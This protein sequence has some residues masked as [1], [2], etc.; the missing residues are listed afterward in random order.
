M[1]KPKQ[2][3]SL[4]H[5]GDLFEA[6]DRK[7]IELSHR[8][9]S[10]DLPLLLLLCS[11]NSWFVLIVS[12]ASDIPTILDLATGDGIL[13]SNNVCCSLNRLKEMYVCM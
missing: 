12:S 9:L 13:S 1:P 3:R 5:W 11:H 7:T 6:D 2:E 10:K 4:P 8:H